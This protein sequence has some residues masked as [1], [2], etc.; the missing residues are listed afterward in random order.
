MI[1][2]TKIEQEIGQ[3]IL[4]DDDP[5]R[6]DIKTDTIT[7]TGI[8]LD[9]D[10]EHYADVEICSYDGDLN[11]TEK[12]TDFFMFFMFEKHKYVEM[13]KEYRE[14]FIYNLKEERQ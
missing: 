6:L 7:I 12:V 14:N 11:D 3:K 10:G 1:D 9:E 5:F 8:A 2:L 4:E 13:L